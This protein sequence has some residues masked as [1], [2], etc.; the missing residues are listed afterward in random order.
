MREAA[1]K[2]KKKYPNYYNED[3]L[4]CADYYSQK[5]WD[6]R[7]KEYYKEVDPVEVIE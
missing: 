3:V 7:V 5:A 1:E 4:N 6:E 2:Y